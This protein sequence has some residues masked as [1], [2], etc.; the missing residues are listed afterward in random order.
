MKD[1]IPEQTFLTYKKRYKQ[2][3]RMLNGLEKTLERKLPEDARRWK[4]SEDQAHYASKQEPH[5]SGWPS[6]P[7]TRS[8]KPETSTSETTTPCPTC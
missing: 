5:Q 1:Y 3:I 4:V 2:C 8:P 7:E 6:D